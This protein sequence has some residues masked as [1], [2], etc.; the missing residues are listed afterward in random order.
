MNPK[1]PKTIT[2]DTER[3]KTIDQYQDI[4]ILEVLWNDAVEEGD[5]GWND[6]K[7]MIK[8]AKRPCP[9]MRTLGYL[10]YSDDHQISLISTLGSE[11]CSRLD[12]IPRAWVLKETVIREGISLTKRKRKA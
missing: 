6:L 8:A 2:N 12:K 4:Q 3:L 11:E 5:I 10:A 1:V 9:V 7:D